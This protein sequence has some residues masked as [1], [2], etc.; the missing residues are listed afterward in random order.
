MLSKE[1]Y[2][3]ITVKGKYLVKYEFQGEIKTKVMDGDE[4]LEIENGGYTVIE[5]YQINKLDKEDFYLIKV[6]REMDYSEMTDFSNFL[7]ENGIKHLI[8]KDGVELKNIPEN[9]KPE[10]L[11]WIKKE[12]GLNNDSEG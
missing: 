8:I 4:L 9:E 12:L 3:T 10:F 2:Q 7:K 11:N 1:D 6:N 5:Y